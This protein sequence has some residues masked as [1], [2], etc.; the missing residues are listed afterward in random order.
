M[1]DQLVASKG[2]IFFGCFFSTFTGYINR[3]RYVALTVCGKLVTVQAVNGYPVSCSTT[4]SNMLFIGIPHCAE[5]TTLRRR[6]H[7]ALKTDSYQRHIITQHQI[8]KRSCTSTP[9]SE[10]DSSIESIHQAGE[11]LMKVSQNWQSYR[12]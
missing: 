6:R 11:G 12:P 2:R 3:I 8:K 1:I 10:E 4:V 5:D 7:L 9:A